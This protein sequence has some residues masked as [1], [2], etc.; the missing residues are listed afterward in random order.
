M[1]GAQHLLKLKFAET[2]W[3]NYHN[4]I[5][6][7]KLKTSSV[8]RIFDAVASLAGLSD[9]SSYEGHAALL[10][11]S[12]AKLFFEDTLNIPAAWMQLPS[13]TSP[14]QIINRIVEQLQSGTPVSA[15]AAWFHVQLVLVIRAIALK[16]N[17]SAICCSGGV[18]QN[19]LLV[20]LVI[21]IMGEDFQ[22]YFNKDLSPNDE[23]IS[24][25]QLTW[26]CIALETSQ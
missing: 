17:C 4:L 13:N 10:L 19:G 12:Q 2:E 25:G 26:Y 8:G 5:R 15:I 23:N 11:E 21:K 18:F 22:V 7:N 24:F 3:L 16:N 1:T 14:K 20:D 9:K 6:V